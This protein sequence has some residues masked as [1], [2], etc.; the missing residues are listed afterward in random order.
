MTQ[1]P[2]DQAISLMQNQ[3]FGDALPLL[4]AVVRVD[5]SYWN[6]WYM[7]G[8]CCRF[9]GDF[10]SAI[11]HLTQAAGL[12]ADQPAVFLALGIALQQQGRLDDA[13]TE[14]RRA[15]EI[16]SD[17]EPAFNSL[18]LTQ[19]MCGELDLALNNYDSGV[20]ALTRRIV[21]TMRNK[22]TSLILKHR[23]TSGML[24]FEH[25][26]YGALFL[27]TNAHG[28]SS[29]AWL[30]GE[31]AIHEERTEKHGGLYW[32]DVPNNK[33]ETT[34]LILPNFFNTYRESLSENSS[35]SNLI[36]NQGTVLEMLGRHDE[37]RQH[38]D[39]ASEFLPQVR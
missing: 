9:L 11:E 21:K 8:Q 31:E 14:L 15:I 22:R 29:M 20:K 19:K 1:D 39:E 12:A 33:N 26:S 18:A 36:G 6:A 10:E 32:I 37:A 4:L 7:A 34:R 38:F 27:T 16:D 30:T 35:Y 24:W 23:D 3:R 25:A 2:I 5:P 17:Y 13:I 28:V